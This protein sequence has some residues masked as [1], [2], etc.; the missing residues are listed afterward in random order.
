MRM[1]NHLTVQGCLWVISC[2]LCIQ[3]REKKRWMETSFGLL[4][5]PVESEIQ[6]HIEGEWK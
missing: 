3:H 6:S 5:P 2:K 1:T 4:V